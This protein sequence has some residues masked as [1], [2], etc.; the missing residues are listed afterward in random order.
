M[1]ATMKAEDLRLS[2]WKAEDYRSPPAP[3][4][5]RFSPGDIVR[6]RRMSEDRWEFGTVSGEVE[7]MRG[8][9]LMVESLSYDA[10]PPV[11][12]KLWE[13]EDPYEVDIVGRAWS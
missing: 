11:W 2:G 10:L 9:T 8:R 4:S 5:S 3:K 1:S 7:V 6:Y 13:T 12:L